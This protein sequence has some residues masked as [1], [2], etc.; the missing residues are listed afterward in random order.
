[1]VNKFVLRL[2]EQ[3]ACKTQNHIDLDL[4]ALHVEWLIKQGPKSMNKGTEHGLA[5]S[6]CV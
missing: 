3:R 4:F 6:M 1:L 2:T 5:M